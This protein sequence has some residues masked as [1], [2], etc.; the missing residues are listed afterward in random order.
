[1]FGCCDMAMAI[2]FAD[3]DGAVDQS[4]IDENYPA[5]SRLVS[6][7]DTTSP[8]SEHVF[9]S[10]GKYPVVNKVMD[11]EG[12]HHKHCTCPCHWRGGPSI[13]C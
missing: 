5:G 8:W 7:Q 3:K 11:Q 4:Y 13:M 10:T 1:M 9:K 6:F 12:N 2:E